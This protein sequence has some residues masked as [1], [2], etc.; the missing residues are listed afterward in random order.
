MK[1]QGGFSIYDEQRDSLFLAIELTRRKSAVS[2][3]LDNNTAICTLPSHFDWF[4]VRRDIE[5]FSSRFESHRGVDIHCVSAV[6]IIQVGA[7]ITLGISLD[8]TP[9]F[10]YRDSFP[11]FSPSSKQLTAARSTFIRGATRLFGSERQCERERKNRPPLSRN[12]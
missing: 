1:I 5:N 4:R 10:Y 9:H 3:L 6:S 12:S 11:F 2:R 8:F 7:I